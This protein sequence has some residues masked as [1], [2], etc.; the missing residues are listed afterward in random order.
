MEESPVGE[1]QSN[2]QQTEDAESQVEQNLQTL[3]R[4]TGIEDHGVADIDQRGADPHG[5]KNVY[6]IY[7]YII[8]WLLNGV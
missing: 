4:R 3:G 6:E 5:E 8:T 2:G 1:H 7:I